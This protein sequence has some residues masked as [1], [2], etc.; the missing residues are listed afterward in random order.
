[1]KPHVVDYYLFSVTC[2]L[3]FQTLQHPKKQPM[4]KARTVKGGQ[5]GQKWSRVVK[6]IN[7]R[8]IS[9]PLDPLTCVPD[10]PTFVLA[11]AERR[12]DGRVPGW[13]VG[14]GDRCVG[15]RGAGV[16]GRRWCRRSGPGRVRPTRP[17]RA[18][19][20]TSMISK[21]VCDIT[22]GMISI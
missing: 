22:V 4:E 5:G 16:G 1:M 14:E 15:R 7:R 3:F 21:R 18:Y 12:V 2:L 11:P 8:P 19:D 9:T 13:S 17:I 6:V 10:P 20:F